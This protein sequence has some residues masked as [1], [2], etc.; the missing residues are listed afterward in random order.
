MQKLSK[1]LLSIVV[2]SMVPLVAGWNR[3]FDESQSEMSKPDIPI[4]YHEE[5]NITIGGL[6]KLSVFD[7]EK[8]GKIYNRIINEFNLS[9]SQFC[10]P[11]GE[12]SQETLLRVHSERYLE[13]L[14]N[15]SVVSKAVYVSL[16]SFVPNFIVQKYLLRPMR[17]ATQGT[18][19]AIDLAVE[20]GWAINLAGGYHHAKHCLAD[21]H[22]IYADIPLAVIR[23]CEEYSANKCLIV[24]LDAHQGNGYEELIG[25]WPQVDIFD[26]YNGSPGFY[27]NDRYAAQF[28]TYDYPVNSFIQDEEYL[29]IIKTGLPKA[30]EQS[31]PDFIIYNAGTDIYDGDR[32][33]QM[34]V[35]REGIIERDEVVFRLAKEHNIPIIMVLSGGYTKESAGIV[36]DSII[37]LANKKIISI[38]KK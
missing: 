31:K 33:G 32:V 21:G 20:Y 10:I 18:I 37:N 23:A 30:I 3:K 5:Y 36:S 13:S 38:E 8:Y 16:L 25:G 15:S 26:V 2:F 11:S 4:I 9:P 35:S 24:D 17:L 14:K 28:I 12:V 34:S 29:S 22:C 7:A 1:L 27:P 19:D 6:A